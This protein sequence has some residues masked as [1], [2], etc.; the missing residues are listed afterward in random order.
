MKVTKTKFGC[1]KL[2]LK[3]TDEELLNFINEFI[4]SN[5]YV[6]YNR[7]SDQIK[8]VAFYQDGYQKELNTEYASIDM[9]FKDDMRLSRILWDMVREGKLYP[10][11]HNDGSQTFAQDTCFGVYEKSYSNYKV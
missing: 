10:V 7:L 9:S 5:G 11:F 4:A 2:P 1:T 3:Y 6:A 8:R